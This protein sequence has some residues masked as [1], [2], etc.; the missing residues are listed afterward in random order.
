M[1]VSCLFVAVFVL[2]AMGASAQN[3]FPTPS[4]NVGIGTSSPASKLHVVDNGRNY[5]V[6][7][8]IAGVTQD[9]QGP[10]YMLLHQIY[11]GTLLA[12]HFVMGKI[13][14]VRGAVGAGNRKWT[15]EV[16][17]ASAYNYNTGSIVSYSEPARLVTLVYNGTSYMAL[18][19]AN[20]PSIYSFSFT[21]YTQNDAFLLVADENV[22]NVQLLQTLY[23]VG[24][25]GRLGAG[26][27]NPWASLHAHSQSNLNIAKFTFGD[28]PPADAFLNIS[29][30]TSATGSYYPGIQGR[31]L[32]PGRVL[33][34]FVQ[35][36]AEDVVPSGGDVSFA[37]VVLEGRSKY[38]S[39]LLNN[40]VLAVN[41]YG[42]NLMMVKADGS[43]GIGTTTT[44]GHK[45]AVNGSGL[46]TKV[47][48][49]AYGSWPDYV[50]QEG[51]ALPSLTEVEQ[52][53]K[54]RQHLPGIPSG[55][56]VKEQGIDLGEMDRKLL[57]K[58][59]E[60]MLY[61]IAQQ[62]QI[63]SL[64]ATNKRMTAEME[65]ISAGRQPPQ[66]TR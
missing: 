62:K 50:F 51:Y 10:N 35:G 42:T 40:N 53:I 43:V 1:K 58:I 15:V 31:S 33:G 19:I 52:H 22:T 17:T 13:S 29:N 55:Q 36:E 60:L 2:A 47:K 20:G 7:R 27:T 48:V 44:H 46:F 3:V 8:G 14:G 28:V 25:Q 11:T 24:I 9:A 45:L 16:N 18:E 64:I 37:A 41:S 49:K 23:P 54:T 32:T 6:N 4:G 65:R 61:T 26:T 56:E 34:I 5:Y 66:N 38:A 63:D 12:D 57:Q 59:E 39:K 21:G 30:G